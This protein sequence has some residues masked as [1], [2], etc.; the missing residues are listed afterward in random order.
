[1]LIGSCAIR[2]LLLYQSRFG[3]FDPGLIYPPQEY[4]RQQ[5]INLQTTSRYKRLSYLGQAR[6][7]SHVQEGIRLLTV[8]LAGLDVIS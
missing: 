7:E 4:V 8:W 2:S 5:I 6:F 3:H 1:M